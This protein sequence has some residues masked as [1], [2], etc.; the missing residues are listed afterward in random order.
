MVLVSLFFAMIAVAAFVFA[1]TVVIEVFGVIF[2]V[3]GMLLELVVGILCIPFWFL[4]A[5]FGG[6]NK[7]HG[8]SPGPAPT[9]EPSR[10]ESRYTPDWSSV[11][12]N[13]KKSRNWS[14]ED[15]GVYCGGHDTHKTLLH[16]HHLDLDPQNN[17][18]WNLVALCVQ[19]HGSMEGVG[20]KRLASA[21]K[22]DGR[23]DAIDHLRWRQGK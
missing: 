9:Y 22:T 16:V 21:A 15:C 7:G 17:S 2:G 14:C 12:R 1:A 4:E 5:L 20:H 11:S 13:Y 6:D 8:S 18:A 19:C 3:I 10:Q 23:W